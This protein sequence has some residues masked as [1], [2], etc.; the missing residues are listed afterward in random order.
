MLERMVLDLRAC[1]L[2][3]WRTPVELE[4]RIVSDLIDLIV[5]DNLE[6]CLNVE[7]PVTQS[8][9]VRERFDITLSTY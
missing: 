5:R 4:C 1:G 3:G 7:I 9:G 6:L 8:Q 2:E